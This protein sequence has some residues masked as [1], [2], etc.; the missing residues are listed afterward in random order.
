MTVNSSWSHIKQLSSS[1]NDQNGGGQFCAK[2]LQ[3]GNGVAGNSK[4]LRKGMLGRRARD[5]CQELCGNSPGLCRTH[6]VGNIAH[7]QAERLPS[8]SGTFSCGSK[9]AI[10]DPAQKL[11][12]KA[13]GRVLRSGET[14]FLSFATKFS[15]QTS[16]PPCP[17]KVESKP[18]L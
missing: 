14:P 8:A 16:A 2:V 10:S 9:A 15:P 5:I 11:L 6:M 13:Q 18:G 17:G 1:F 12:S 3:P 7:S 4:Q